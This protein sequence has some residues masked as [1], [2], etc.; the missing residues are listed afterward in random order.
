MMF[1]ETQRGFA[2]VSAI[3]L[4]VILAALGGFIAT[5]STSQQIGSALDVMGARAYQAARAGTEWG[6]YRAIKDSS[7]V[8]S[9]DIGAID[10]MSV[11]VTCT[12]AAA[13]GVVEA[14]LGTIY[15]ITAVACSVPAASPACPGAVANP[16][17]VERRV[18]VLAEK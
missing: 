6:L 16:N 3:F 14:G 13:G 9:T 4:V 17:Y 5:V 12:A 7:C 1:P 10:S 15:S 18:T 8:A 2:I 11:T